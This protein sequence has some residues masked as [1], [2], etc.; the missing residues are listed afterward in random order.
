MRYSLRRVE[1]DE[2]KIIRSSAEAGLEESV[3]LFSVK[4]RACPGRSGHAHLRL[5][6]PP[7][8][9]KGSSYFEVG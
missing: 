9:G 6:A 2:A 8:T 1:T 4:V 7:C 5:P 3:I